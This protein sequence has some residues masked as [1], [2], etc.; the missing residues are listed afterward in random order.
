MK[1]LALMAFVSIAMIACKKEE[2]KPQIITQTNTVHDTTHSTSTVHD[3]TY[4]SPMGLVGAWE[5]YKTETIISGSSTFYPQVWKYNFTSS[6]MNQD[7][8]NDGTYEYSYSAVY[9]SNYVDITY[10]SIPATYTYVV[11][12]V[13]AEYRLT[14]VVSSTQNQVWY[15]RK[16]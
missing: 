8:D 6:M 11:T 7:L 1:K 2:C 13:G 5:C 3:T 4:M 16:Y 12:S 10:P 15:L 9:G 14:R